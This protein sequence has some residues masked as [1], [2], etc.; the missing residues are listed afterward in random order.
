LRGIDFFI[1]IGFGVINWSL[2]KIIKVQR[3]PPTAEIVAKIP[4]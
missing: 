2:E 3:K 1:L 4:Q